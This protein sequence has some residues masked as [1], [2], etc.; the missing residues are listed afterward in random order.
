MFYSIVLGAPIESDLPKGERGSGACQ[1]RYVE[2]SNQRTWMSALSSFHLPLSPLA[3]LHF[4]PEER[5]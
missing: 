2:D 1:H 5:V 3:A 4:L